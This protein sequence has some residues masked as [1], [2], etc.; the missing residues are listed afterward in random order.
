MGPP[1]QTLNKRMR[2]VGTT[3]VGIVLFCVIGVVQAPAAG[4]AGL[5]AS[6]AYSPST[7]AF[8]GGRNYPSSNWRD[9]KDRAMQECANT[10]QHPGD[11]VWLGSGP[12]VSLAVGPDKSQFAGGVGST[13]QASD[14]DALWPSPPPPTGKFAHIEGAT[15]KARLCAN[16]QEPEGLS[17]TV[18]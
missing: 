18:G 4:T 3:I 1:A 11:C 2:S 12:C 10:A 15:I 9:G 5:V 7:G 16:G 8:G 14:H 17:G 13:P 6:I